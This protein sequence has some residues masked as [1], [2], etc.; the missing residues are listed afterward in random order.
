MNGLYVTDR[1]AKTQQLAQEVAAVIAL[2]TPEIWA[3]DGRALLCM[4]DAWT[5]CQRLAV[6]DAA[7][8]FWSCSE[9]GYEEGLRAAGLLP[10]P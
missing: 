1:L 4:I 5:T 3:A 10:E 7:E 8:R 9:G 2:G 6:I